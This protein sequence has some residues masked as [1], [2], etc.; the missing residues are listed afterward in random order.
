[1][2]KKVLA[3]ILTGVSLVCMT[4]VALSDSPKGE[5]RDGMGGYDMGYGMGMMGMGPMG[6]SGT[7]HGMDYDQLNLSSSQHEKISAIRSASAENYRQLGEEIAAR[8]EELGVLK[9]APDADMAAIGKKIDEIAAL[10]NK[11]T[12]AKVEEH[13][14]ILAVLTP[15]QKKLLPYLRSSL[16]H[17]FYGLELTGSQKET[18]AGLEEQARPKIMELSEK[19]RN[20]ERAYHENLYSANFDRNGALK[21]GLVI[22]KT[23]SELE[24]V[25][26]ELYVKAYKVLTPEQR[27]KL[28]SM[29]GKMRGPM[30]ERRDHERMEQK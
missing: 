23:Y 26:T 16:L 6:Y 29:R 2:R 14:K 17:R 8:Y 21:D 12:S 18:I 4:A 5:M 25:K 13:E 15:E 10:Y 30:M 28:E 3:G 19:L 7:M 1:M 27:A 22:S 20:Q 11:M 9:K 24:K